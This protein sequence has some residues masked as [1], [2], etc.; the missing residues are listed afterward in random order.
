MNIPWIES[1]PNHWHTLRAKNMFEKQNRPICDQDDVVT[2][3]RDGMVTLRKN[4]RTTGFTES[5]QWSGYQGVRKG[6]LVIHVMDAFAGAI[7]VSDSDGKSTPVYSVCTPKI[8]LNNYYYAYLLREMARTGFIQSL[9]RGIRERSSDFRF[10]VFAG[11]NL[12][13]PPRDEQDQIVRYLDWKV[14]QINKLINVKKRQIVILKEKRR[15]LIDSVIGNN[16][17]K[18]HRFKNIFLLYKGLGITKADLRDEGI[19]CVNYGDIHSRY[20]FEVNPR[21]HALKNV[22]EF[23]LEQSPKSLLQNGDF[24]FADTSED[25]VG[26]GNFTYLNSDVKTFA[27]YHTIIARA[28]LQLKHRYVAYYFD[29]YKFRTQIRQRVN[30]VKVY[31]ITRS[32]LNSTFVELPNEAMQDRIVAM[33][34]RACHAIDRSLELLNKELLLFAEYRIRLISDVVTG[35]KDVGDITIPQYET[36]EITTEDNKSDTEDEEH[37]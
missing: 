11:L 15:N 30:G 13:L 10:E 17:G 4:R 23:Y 3:F 8:D 16:E 31:S 32:I 22:D 19:P 28:S 6:D 12:P 33:L 2:C 14:S 1:M 20:G 18:K 24:I 21:C 25:L 29:S 27:G 5:T 34:D 37:G 35:K 36:T 26:S 9:Y 7:G